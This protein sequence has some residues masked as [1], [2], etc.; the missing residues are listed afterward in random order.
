MGDYS[1]SGKRSSATSA[2]RRVERPSPLVRKQLAATSALL[3]SP[4]TFKDKQA[5][6]DMYSRG[7]AP[8]EVW[9]NSGT[10]EQMPQKV[11]LAWDPQ[12]QERVL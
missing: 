12:Q 5:L 3:C 10:S 1:F 8:W 7:V 6:E 11:T 9:K 2:G 4:L